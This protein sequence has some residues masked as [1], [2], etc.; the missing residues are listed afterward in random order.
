MNNKESCIKELAALLLERGE[1][2]ERIAAILLVK[3]C[4][5]Y[6]HRM[7]ARTDGEGYII[8]GPH[9]LDEPFLSKD[10]AIKAWLRWVTEKQHPTESDAIGWLARLRI[11]D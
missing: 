11:N 7:R 4:E 8:T 3:D 5:L 10:K 1:K 2:H 6:E 9:Y